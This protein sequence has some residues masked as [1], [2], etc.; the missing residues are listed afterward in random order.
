MSYY[1]N[2]PTKSTPNLVSHNISCSKSNEEEEE[3]EDHEDYSDD[4]FLTYENEPLTI[5]DNLSTERDLYKD[6]V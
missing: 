2:L 3:D 5:A 4:D 6:D 1:R